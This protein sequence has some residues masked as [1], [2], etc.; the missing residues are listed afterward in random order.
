MLCENNQII[1]WS[2]TTGEPTLV[3]EF[4]EF[5][6][7]YDMSGVVLGTALLT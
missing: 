4:S 2:L 6:A 5:D 7:I 3:G 1:K